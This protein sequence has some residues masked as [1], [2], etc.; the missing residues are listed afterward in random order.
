MKISRAG[1]LLGAL[2]ALPLS[3]AEPAKPAAAAENPKQILDEMRSDLQALETEAVSKGVSMTVDE[4]TK[5]WPVFKKFQA[6][7][8]PIIDAQVAA[9]R[10]Y[11]ENYA[12]L[13]D[14]D[15]VAYVN[16]LLERDQR[17]HDLRVKYLAEY[18]K[19]LPAGKAA[20][21]VHISRRVGLAAQAK[22]ATLIPLVH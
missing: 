15:S 6:E 12:A 7:Q 8:A 13:T 18:S 16:A 21:V 2:I 11:A 19:V 17:I 3:A 20:R 22:L 10:K 5:F 9:V 14:Q 1:L 4:Q